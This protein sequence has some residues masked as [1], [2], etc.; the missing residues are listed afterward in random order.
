MES[1]RSSPV[2]S[3]QPRPKLTALIV[4]GA[5]FMEFL[6]STIIAPALPDMAASFG[7]SAVDLNIGISAY[8]M[9]VAVFIPMSGWISDR[10]G[11]RR[12][13][14]SAIIVFTVASALCGVSQ[15]LWTF[16][17]A[18]ILQGIGGAMMV[19]VGRLVVLRNTEKRN[20]MR[21]I[22][23]LTW[24]GLAAPI[25]GPPLGGFITTYASWH[26]IFLINVPLG[27]IALLLAVVV[28]R[29]ARVAARSPFDWIGFALTGSA[30][31]GFM[32]GFDQIA[33][34]QSQWLTPG[35]VLMASIVLGAA[36]LRRARRKSHPLLDV[37]ALRVQ[38]FAAMVRAGFVFRAVVSAIPFLLP[39]MFQ[40]AFGL[41]PFVSGLLVLALFSGNLGIKPLT[42]GILKRF[43]FR[44]TLLA[45]GLLFSLTTFACAL[46]SPDTPLAIIV[47]VLFFGGVTRSMQ[48]T[49]NITLAFVDVREEQLSGA[50]TLFNMMT[51]IGL[52]MGIA[53][54]AIALRL[55]HS[56]TGS[57]PGP[58][59]LTDFQLAFATIGALALLA[60]IDC[61]ALPPEAGSSISGHGANRTTDS[62][63]RK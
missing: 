34:P 29:D 27:A 17:A 30:C 3:V 22:A 5:F 63:N 35:L 45:N 1:S 2:P 61:F 46:F 44:T 51:Q 16:T 14:A 25:V 18:R 24:P 62:V 52:A 15:G 10:F 41:N 60:L 13:F 56:V 53:L 43:G 50:N 8:L 47:I 58:L 40:I 57:T 19:P 21:A 11:I 12:V 42:S 59:S 49:A 26:W 20:L 39:L 36:S 31:I 33:Q 7:I 28:I 9:T 54:G 32:Y 4:A 38:T 6:D 23:T 37:S 55:A 48:F